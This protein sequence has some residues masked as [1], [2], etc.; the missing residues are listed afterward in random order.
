M[1]VCVWMADYRGAASEAKRAMVL[2]RKREKEKEEMEMKRQKIT[3]VSSTE[4]FKNDVVNLYC[5]LRAESTSRSRNELKINNICTS[6]KFWVVCGKL[7]VTLAVI[8]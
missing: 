7:F 6:R 4:H 8:A 3:D 2:M 5:F 1:G